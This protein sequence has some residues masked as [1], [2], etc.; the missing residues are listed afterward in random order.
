MPGTGSFV[1]VCSDHLQKRRK[2]A[3]AIDVGRTIR[4][5]VQGVGEFRNGKVARLRG[6]ANKMLLMGGGASHLR[7]DVCVRGGGGLM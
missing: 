2:A 4:A 3:I 1:C 5:T 7:L 6:W